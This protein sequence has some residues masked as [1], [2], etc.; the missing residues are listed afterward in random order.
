MSSLFW[1]GVV[2]IFWSLSV[3]FLSLYRKFRVHKLM[4]SD[5]KQARD[6]FK[7]LKAVSTRRYSKG[8]SV[9]SPILFV[10]IFA[11]GLT[12]GLLIPKSK[13]LVYY[14]LK[15]QRVL[16]PD[17]LALV[18]KETGP[19][20]G[21]FCPDNKVMQYEPREGYVIC[22]LEYTDRGCMDISG[23]NG[24]ITWVKDKY[25]S[26]TTLTDSDTYKPYP[27]CTK[28]ELIAQGG[29]NAR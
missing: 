3:L 9:Y 2:L 29:Y 18:S 20:R 12:T 21:D 14:D 5:N 25:K 4:Q 22:K 17:S 10:V 26:T 15:V 16:P 19:F 11:M 27:E 1:V 28:D 13:K 8:W 23:H 7:E 6:I 24:S